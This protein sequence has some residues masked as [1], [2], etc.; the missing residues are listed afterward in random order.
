MARWSQGE[1][2]EYNLNRKKE[3]GLQVQKRIEL[4]EEL[5]A[6]RRIHPKLKSDSKSS[7]SFPQSKLWEL[8]DKEYGI[9]KIHRNAAKKQIKKYDTLIQPLSRLVLYGL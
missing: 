8:E 4:L 9:T 6:S 3:T 7:I 5:A 1:T 2:S